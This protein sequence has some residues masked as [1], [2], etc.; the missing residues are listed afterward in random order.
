MSFTITKMVGD[1][2]FWV[3]KCL[4]V[5]EALSEFGKI[6]CKI[7]TRRNPK[8]FI[9]LYG[10]VCVDNY[11]EDGKILYEINWEEDGPDGWRRQQQLAELRRPQPQESTVN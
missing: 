11:V 8:A 2:R 3:A 10:G 7:F 1:G 6:K 4:E 9:K 5:L